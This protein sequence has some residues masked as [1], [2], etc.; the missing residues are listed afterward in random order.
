MCQGR[1]VEFEGDH[2]R[3]GGRLGLVGSE[4]YLPMCGGCV[5]GNAGF[6]VQLRVVGVWGGGGGWS[7]ACAAEL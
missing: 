4:G 7:G 5:V 1:A 3:K 6:C 2:I